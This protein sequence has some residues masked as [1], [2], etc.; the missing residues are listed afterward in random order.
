MEANLVLSENEGNSSSDTLFTGDI[1]HQ[2]L[3]VVGDGI[4][5]HTAAGSTI[6]VGTGKFLG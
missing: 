1:H 5:F 2:Q 4:N 6:N 3:G